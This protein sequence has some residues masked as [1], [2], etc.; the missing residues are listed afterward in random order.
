LR[1]TVSRFGNGIRCPSMSFIICRTVDCEAVAASS[2]GPV[3]R[4]ADEAKPYDQGEDQ[5]LSM[6]A[7]WCTPI[8][9][10][11]ILATLSFNSFPTLTTMLRGALRSKSHVVT[12]AVVELRTSPMTSSPVEVKFDA[13][14]ESAVILHIVH[15]GAT[16][17]ARLS[18]QEMP[19]RLERDAGRDVATWR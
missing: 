11:R 16:R 7:C 13:V 17:S 4:G 3:R 5:G 6:P 2:P 9:S 15:D 8:P 14:G 12:A 18:W 19:H 1:V 10:L